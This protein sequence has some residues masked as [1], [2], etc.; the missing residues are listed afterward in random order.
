MMQVRSQKVIFWLVHRQV[1]RDICKT[2]QDE[3]EQRAGVA[4]AEL[5]CELDRAKMSAA[6]VSGLANRGEELH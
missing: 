6:D 2:L 3:A 1:F 4:R 5:L